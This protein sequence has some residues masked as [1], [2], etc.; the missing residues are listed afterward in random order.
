LS[1]AGVALLAGGS[2]LVLAGPRAEAQIV[3]PQPAP[4]TDYANYPANAE[5]PDGCDAGGVSGVSFRVNGQTPVIGLQDLG[6]LNAGDTVTM[7]WLAVGE[8]C[9]PPGTGQVPIVLAMK[10]AP[11][12]VFDASVDQAL[13]LP[14]ALG[15]L[16][17]GLGEHSISYVLPDL[18]DDSFPGCFGQLDAIV[19]LPLAVVGP[20]GSFYSSGLRGSGPNL[21]ISAWNGGYELCV[22]QETTTTTGGTTSTTEGTTTTSTP[23][24]TTTTALTT[25]TTGATTTTV[26]PSSTTVLV[27]TSVTD[28]TSLTVGA[29]GV[30]ATR[31]LAETGRSSGWVAL[32]GL[33]G[34]GVGL[35]LLVVSR[36]RR[37]V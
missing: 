28:P 3:P 8:E 19:G 18:L 1:A 20:G 22:A 37:L 29:A 35:V 16:S 2:L 17:A 21:L 12:P 6:P 25:T 5:V 9:D 32:A 15:F 27:S 13:D 10:S 4:V 33:V 23:T 11:G 14:Y 30:Q 34:V 26:P 31:T 24:S 36:R 7:T